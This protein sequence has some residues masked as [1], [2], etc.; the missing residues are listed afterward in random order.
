MDQPVVRRNRVASENSGK[1]ALN[2]KRRGDERRE[3]E[4]SG[5]ERIGERRG[6]ER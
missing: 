3:E 2:N 5:V 4:W 6:E 1:A